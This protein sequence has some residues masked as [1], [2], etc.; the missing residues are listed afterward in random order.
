MLCLI[1]GSGLY[2]LDDP[3]VILIKEYFDHNKF[4]YPSD[5]IQKLSY[6]GNEFFFLPRHGKDHQWPAHRLP[7]RANFE[8]LS[9]LGVKH[10]FSHCACGSLKKDLNPGSFVILDQFVDFTKR[11]DD[12]EPTNKFVHLPMTYPYCEFGRNLLKG[13]ISRLKYNYVDSGTVV[14]IEGPRFSTLAESLMYI[15]NGWDV[16]NMTQ[17][18]ECYIAR[19]YGMNYTAF[20]SITDY[21]PG[22]DEVKREISPESINKIKIFF[23]ENAGRSKKIFLELVLE[24]NVIHEFPLIKNTF[25]EF[26]R[27]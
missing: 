10:I 17:Y 4:G 7:Y 9:N 12:F 13:V 1:S 19:E 6:R 18:P 8:A 11:A 20:A 24:S 21:S 5:V 14:V 3:E 2:S 25:K 26:F 22:L 16:V 15:R 23:K 27:K